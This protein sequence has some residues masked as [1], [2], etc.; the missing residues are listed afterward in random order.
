MRTGDTLS[1]VMHVW[2][3]KIAWYV[4][5]AEPGGRKYI[6]ARGMADREFEPVLD[7]YG[8]AVMSAAYEAYR[9]LGE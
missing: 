2:N 8:Q 3:G 5:V 6:A 9:E 7:T 4:L 1:L